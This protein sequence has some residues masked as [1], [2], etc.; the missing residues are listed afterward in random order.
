MF[1]SVLAPVSAKPEGGC[2][3][4]FSFL[5]I[6]KQERIYRLEVFIV[7]GG[8]EVDGKWCLMYLPQ[9]KFQRGHAFIRRDWV[10]AY[11]YSRQNMRG[12]DY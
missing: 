8:A 5:E 12:D 3:T 4:E 11:Q 7:E 2:D 9:Y 10:V 1:V 6:D